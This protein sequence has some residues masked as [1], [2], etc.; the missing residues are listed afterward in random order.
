MKLYF[1]IIIFILSSNLNF[2]YINPTWGATGH[3]T[4]G[5]IAENHLR[6]KAKKQINKLLLGQ[7][8]AFVST[9]GD[10][11]KS[12]KRYGKFNSWHYVNYPFDTKYENSRR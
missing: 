11:I 8:L 2:A 6:K 3:R 7:S 9:Y 10:E 1:L 5:K 4:V 12:D